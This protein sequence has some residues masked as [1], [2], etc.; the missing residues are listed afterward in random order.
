LQ[1]RS[2]TTRIVNNKR[3]TTGAI[4]IRCALLVGSAAGRHGPIDFLSYLQR[5][6]LTLQP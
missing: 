5:L 3:K 2:V 1:A 6:S 4:P